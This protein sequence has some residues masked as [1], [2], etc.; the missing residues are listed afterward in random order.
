MILQ[1][2]VVVGVI[3][4]LEGGAE[5]KPQGSILGM[6]KKFR[7]NVPF[8]VRGGRKRNTEDDV[9]FQSFFGSNVSSPPLC[10]ICGQG[11]Q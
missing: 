5:N 10:L 2:R 3:F 4:S 1:K 9:G 11:F 6:E 7:I 8:S